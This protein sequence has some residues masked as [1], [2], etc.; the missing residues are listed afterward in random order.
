M[1]TVLLAGMI[2]LT[3]VS[4][5]EN[6]RENLAGTPPL[7]LQVSARPE[8]ASS[9][10]T[11]VYLFSLYCALG[12]CSLNM[13]VLNRCQTREG[14]MN[15]FVPEIHDWSTWSGSLKVAATSDHSLEV[16]IFQATHESLPARLVYEYSRN[17]QGDTKGTVLGFEASGFVNLETFPDSLEYFS[18]IP[19]QG[20]SASLSLECPVLLNGISQSNP[21]RVSK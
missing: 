18:L 21:K 10:H 6:N 2:S 9:G 5:A 20:E 17:S 16:T 8:A 12:R 1:T 11:P 14:G 13:L 15:A 4:N 7:S 3:T 19:I